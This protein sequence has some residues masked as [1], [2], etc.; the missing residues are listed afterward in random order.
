MRM[1]P[2]AQGPGRA[3]QGPG[4]PG[5][6]R[7]GP[8]RRPDLEGRARGPEARCPGPPVPHTHTHAD[9]GE[10]GEALRHNGMRRYRC[11]GAYCEC[12]EECDRYYKI[13]HLGDPTGLA[14]AEA[15]PSA[16]G[17]RPPG[18]ATRGAAE[19]AR[20]RRL[21]PKGRGPVPRAL[22]PASAHAYLF[23][24][25]LRIA[26]CSSENKDFEQRAR[27]AR[28]HQSRQ[29]ITIETGGAQRTKTLIAKRTQTSMQSS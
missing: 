29:R 23:L 28:K 1:R 19:A 14:I 18:R 8:P 27:S 26:T 16:P 10:T 9:H 24:S 22:G 6:R 3:R 2:E 5:A 7:G 17:P 15:P 4:P 12:S 11:I 25:S 21:R 13:S 20:P